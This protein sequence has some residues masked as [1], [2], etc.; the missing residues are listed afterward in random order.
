MKEPYKWDYTIRIKTKD[1]TYEYEDKLDNLES[2]IEKHKGYEE[3]RAEHNKPKTLSMRRNN[4][5]KGII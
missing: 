1:G 2:I 3:V 5:R 4:G